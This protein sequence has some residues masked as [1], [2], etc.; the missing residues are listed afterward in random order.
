MSLGTWFRSC[1]GVLLAIQGLLLSWPPSVVAV[2][3]PIGWLQAGMGAG[4]GAHRL[5]GWAGWW[6]PREGSEGLLEE[7]CL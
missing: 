3:F 5:E 1:H 2:I 4:M 7:G 6:A